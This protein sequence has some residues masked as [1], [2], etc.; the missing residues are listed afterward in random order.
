MID[1]AWKTGCRQSELAKSQ[2]NDVDHTRRQL[3]VRGKRNKV[4]VIDLDGWGYDIYRALPIALGSRWVFWHDDGEP[5]RNVASRFA[6]IVK[7]V[8]EAARKREQDFRPFPFHHLRHR[9]A[10]DWL[11]SGRNIYDLQQRLGHR[12]IKTTEIYLD[13]LTAEEQ[14]AVKFSGPQNADQLQRF[15]A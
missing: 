5:Y 7:S 13:Y 3:T 11:K 10:V 9:R 6:A 2:I 15:T 14:R 12:S 1:A 4:R 8:A